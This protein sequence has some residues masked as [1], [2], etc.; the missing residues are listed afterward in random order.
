MTLPFSLAGLF[1]AD[2]SL[3]NGSLCSACQSIADGRL[4]YLGMTYFHSP[5]QKV[6]RHHIRSYDIETA[7]QAGCALCCILWS[8]FSRSQKETI[9]AQSGELSVVKQLANSNLCKDGK[10]LVALI[11]AGMAG[12]RTRRSRRSFSSLACMH[13]RSSRYR[14]FQSPSSV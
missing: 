10:A 1:E 14:S 8:R 5:L 6:Y 11:L 7:A 13:Q 2:T 4:T 3:T 12:F 9:R